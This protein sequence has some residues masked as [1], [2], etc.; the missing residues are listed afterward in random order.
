MR[1]SLSPRSRS[2]SAPLV[3]ASNRGPVEFSEGP[4]GAVQGRRGGGGL[5]AILGP[6]IASSGGVWIAAARSTTDRRVA[7]HADDNN[8]LITVDLPQGQIAMRCLELDE[9]AFAAYYH[10]V[11]TQTL[12]FLHHHLFDLARS[13]L[14]GPEF[15]SDWLAYE[16]I[17]EVFAA[18][19]ADEVA[20]GGTVLLQDYH[21]AAAPALLRAHRPDVRIVHCTMCPWA[22]PGYFATLPVW[23]ARRLIDGMLAADLLSFFA[24]RW[25]SCFLQ[26]CADLGYEVEWSSSSVGG[27]NGHATA[28]RAF[29]VGV[30]IGDLRAQ[31]SSP[32]GQAEAA[33]VRELVGEL[34]LILRVDR[35]EPAKN[36]VR[37]IA[38]F[39]AFLAANPSARGTV[40]HYVL[41]YSSRGDTPDYQRY[42]AEVRHL[43]GAVNE[44][45]R[46]DTWEP[47]VL[48][49][50]NNFERGLALM[51][52]A[53]VLVVN[54]LRDGMNLVAKE[55]AAVSENNVVVILSQH[56]GA[57]DDLAAGAIVINPFDTAELAGAIAAGLAMPPA[58][59]S[60]RLMM[61]REAAGAISPEDWLAS[62]LAKLDRIRAT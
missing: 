22:D 37:G 1:T 14:F 6:A 12:W 31:L 10:R 49:T 27:N 45:F 25:V 11:A 59:R 42:A 58:E 61:L 15:R 41:A 5:I 46:T 28:V 57:A 7:R 8:Q 9:E 30:D 17:N 36:I 53:D 40:L 26:S 48:D 55:T 43:V 18:A 13:P 33:A 19:C 52:Q 44:R 50:H 23:M 21:L 20:P 35:L 51:A 56:A 34:R 60:H 16:R 47:M 24:P 4:D 38:G 32:R 54:P 39:E 62:L 3:I 2:R 29:P